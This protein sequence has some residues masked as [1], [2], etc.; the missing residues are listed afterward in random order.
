MAHVYC[1]QTAVDDGGGDEGRW[2][3]CSDTTHGLSDDSVVHVIISCVC[4]L[5]FGVEFKLKF[6]TVATDSFL[7]PLIDNEPRNARVRMKINVCDT[8][9]STNHP[10]LTVENYIQ[11]YKSHIR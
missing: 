7:S 5:N 4:V 10:I 6:S 1:G 9:N 3:E 8:S 11:N 2:N